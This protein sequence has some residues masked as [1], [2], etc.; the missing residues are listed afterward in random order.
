MQVVSVV[1][2]L[3]LYDLPQHGC[4]S[5]KPFPSLMPPPRLTL[6]KPKNGFLKPSVCTID[7]I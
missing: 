5:V 7:I 6:A 2:H 3:K 1:A 4:Q